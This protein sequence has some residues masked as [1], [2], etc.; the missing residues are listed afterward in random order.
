[1]VSMW[2]PGRRLAPIV[3]NSITRWTRALLGFSMQLAPIIVILVSG[4]LPLLVA[5]PFHSVADVPHREAM[6][7]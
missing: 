1:M 6:S 2:R 5:F 4:Q 3:H 7:K